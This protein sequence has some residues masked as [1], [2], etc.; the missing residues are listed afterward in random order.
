MDFHGLDITDQKTSAGK[1]GDAQSTR[2]VY[3]RINRFYVRF[4]AEVDSFDVDL[5]SKD[6]HLPDKAD[7][8]NRKLVRF[9]ITSR[10]TFRKLLPQPVTWL[11]L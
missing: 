11:R 8:V 3:S 5:V 9:F 6:L 2:R 7:H 4:L 10:G 1:E